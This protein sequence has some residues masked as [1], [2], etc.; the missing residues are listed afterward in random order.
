MSTFSSVALIVSLL[1]TP[2]SPYLQ[3]HSNHLP[4]PC[5]TCARALLEDMDYRPCCCSSTR[6]RRTIR[7]QGAPPVEKVSAEVLESST[8]AQQPF[9]PSSIAATTTANRT[10]AASSSSKP[11]SSLHSLSTNRTPNNGQRQIKLLLMINSSTKSLKKAVSLGGRCSVSSSP[12]CSRHS[13]RLELNEP[14][15]MDDFEPSSFPS[16]SPSDVPSS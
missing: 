10:G 6:K 3:H 13:R 7:R 1:Q 16:L 14:I 5:A 2:S 8:L 9:D 15:E 4:C 12:S 11:T